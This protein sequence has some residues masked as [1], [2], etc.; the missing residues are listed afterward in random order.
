M[1]IDGRLR[2]SHMSVEDNQKNATTPEE[3][4]V[5]DFKRKSKQIIQTNET[6]TLLY[7]QCH[8]NSG[9]SY[10]PHEMYV[11]DDVLFDF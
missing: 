7:N 10:I 6:N 11:S 4:N 9:L 8:L 5:I 1:S 3:S 2:R